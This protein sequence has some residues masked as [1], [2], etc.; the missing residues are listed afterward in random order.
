LDE[1]GLSIGLS[2]DVIREAGRYLKVDKK[3]VVSGEENMRERYGREHREETGSRS[4][5]S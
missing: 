1:N 4:G 3:I 2:D 5:S